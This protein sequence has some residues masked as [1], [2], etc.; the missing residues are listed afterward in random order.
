MHARCLF[1][2]ALLRG[3]P[4]GAQGWVQLPDLP[5]VAR[6]DAS[7]FAADSAVFVGT[8]M[9]VGFQL[10]NDWHRYDPASSSW[11]SIAPMPATPRQYGTGFSVG[12]FGYVFGGVEDAG[13][14][15]EL[16]VYLPVNAVWYALDTMPG[17]PRSGSASFVLGVRAFVVGG[18][19]GPGA[20][21]TDE[22]WEYFPFLNTWLPRP[23]MP[24]TPRHLAAVFTQGGKAYVVGGRAGDGSILNDG[25][26]YD[27]AMDTWSAIAPLPAAGRFGA[28]GFRWP[29]GGIVLAGAT[30][31]STL[32]RECWRYDAATD[33]WSSLPEFPGAARK[34]GTGAVVNDVVYYG[35]GSD[36]AQRF[37]DWWALHTDVRVTPDPVS[38][39]PGVH[40]NP[41]N[42][43]LTLTWPGPGGPLPFTIRD[44]H[45]RSV[46]SGVSA[47]G[48]NVDVSDLQPGAYH[49]TIVTRDGPRTMPVLRIP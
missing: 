22:L 25:W 34:G 30:S 24:G 9:D 43:R 4:A 26:C 40:P 32:L 29:G 15:N 17:L 42:G 33:S 23:P 3:A 38:S 21:L 10:T 6:D 37:A 48:L 49:L 41:T 47:D 18:R 36:G 20:A 1:M 16:F 19:T 39:A 31:D 27:G 46:R 45:G 8:G 28:E 2:L 35:T 14:S 5:A 11:T 7:A 12:G 13:L 44:T